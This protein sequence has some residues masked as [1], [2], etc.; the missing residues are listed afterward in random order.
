[1]P[2]ELVEIGLMDRELPHYEGGL[3]SIGDA[4]A[5]VLMRYGFVGVD[6]GVDNGDGLPNDPVAA[7]CAA[8]FDVS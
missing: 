3:C 6:Q 4:I 1:M 5:E 2:V 7:C 8:G